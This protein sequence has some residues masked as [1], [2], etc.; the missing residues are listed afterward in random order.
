MTPY[1]RGN[2]DGLLWLASVAAAKAE[3]Y[4]AE[5]D[6]CDRVLANPVNRAQAN[7]ARVLHPWAVARMAAWLDVA[8]E[9]ERMAAAMP[10]D[11]EHP[12]EAP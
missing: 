3:T 1:Q 11:P 6:R 12:E 5:A 8:A 10:E 7:A 4:R 9:A 2:R